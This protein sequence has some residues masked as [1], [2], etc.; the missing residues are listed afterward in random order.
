MG[1]AATVRLQKQR[2][3]FP[4]SS[5]CVETNDALFAPEPRPSIFRLSP[6]LRVSPPRYPLS[7]DSQSVS[8]DVHHQLQGGVPVLGGLTPWAALIVHGA[9]LRRDSLTPASPPPQLPRSPLRTDAKQVPTNR[10]LAETVPLRMST[11]R[12][13]ALPH[14]RSGSEFSGP[15]AEPVLASVSLRNTLDFRGGLLKRQIEHKA[16]SLCI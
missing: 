15:A 9:F 8:A 5:P 11:G 16:S 2:S 4:V 7:P 13:N 3:L 14:K 1:P 6:T 12:E 10:H